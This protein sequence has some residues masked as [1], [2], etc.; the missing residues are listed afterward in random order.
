MVGSPTLSVRLGSHVTLEPHASGEIVVHVQGQ[1]FSLGTFSTGIADRASELGSSVPFSSFEADDQPSDDEMHLLV[2]RLAMHGLLEYRLR[3]SPQ[4]R[5]LVVIEPQVPDYW[6]RLPQLVDKDILVLSRF[7]Y[8]RRRGSD[9][10]LESPRAGA[11]FKIVDPK[12]ASLI[13]SLAEPQAVNS[14]RKQSGFPGIELLALMVD[15]QVAFKMRGQS[16]N[17]LRLVEGDDDLVL[18]DFHDLLFHT[19]STEGRHANPLGGVYRYARRFPPQPAVRPRWP[20]KE[21]KLKRFLTKRQET[22]SPVATLLRQRHSTRVFD[23]QRPITID[24]LSR[25]LE[26]TAPVLSEGTNKLGFGNDGPAVG[27]TVRPYPSAGASFELELYLAVDKCKGLR[28]GFYHYDA[29][30]HG[31]VSIEVRN[32]QLEA[33][34]MKG[35]FAMG[36]PSLPQILITMAARFGRISW[37]YSSIAYALILKDVGVLT[38]TLYLMATELGLG[39]CA[40]GIANIDLFA[41]MT[42]LGIHV[43]GPVG[44]FALGREPQREPNLHS[45]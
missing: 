17:G 33:M 29:S 27:Y 36:V 9:M 18:W 14:L 42:G 26:G 20:G 37:K 40:I 3:R 23:D 11:L 12:I 35:A 39:G 2:R 7:A 5:D 32:N 45:T 15:C 4:G 22:I 13:A 43:E 31:L 38:Q 21:F 10:V 44:Q 41:R 28:Q 30:E 6:P 8:M 16:D 25:F 19:R 34:L 24:E 1:S